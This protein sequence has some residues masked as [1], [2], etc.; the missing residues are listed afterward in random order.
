MIRLI[1]GAAAGLV[2][3]FSAAL[4]Q[5]PAIGT[6]GKSA[7]G[8]A[9]APAE[10]RVTPKPVAPAAASAAASEG[11]IRVLLI[12]MR[13]TTLSSPVAARI[14]RFDVSLGRAF[15]AGQT[16]ITFECDEPVARVN[17]A[18]AELAGAVETHEAKVRMQ[19]LDQASDV[20]VALAASAVAKA[21][22]QIALYAAQVRQC[23]LN[24][25]WAGRVSKLHV[26]RHMSVTPGQPLLDLVMDGPLRL[27]LNVPSSA[28]S[29]IKT[30]QTFEVNIDETGKTYLARIAAINS[31]IDA[32]SQTIE[33][34]AAMVAQ[35]A[36]L[37]P[38]MSG[39]AKIAGVP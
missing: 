14:S 23:S 6:A 15:A 34:E 19:G 10:T 13:E 11:G 38:G 27:K 21:R 8:A 24:A 16:L 3:T 25:P 36:S 35:Y 37:L 28:L 39:T 22:A 5:S 30:G 9:R 33:V 1:P 17:M 26:A 12:A 20:E 7:A 32:V 18:K 2:L 4:A 29:K 31:R